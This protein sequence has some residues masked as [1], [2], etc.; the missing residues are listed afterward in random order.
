MSKVRKITI[1]ALG[2]VGTLVAVT[3]VGTILITM[4]KL[5]KI[6]TR[7]RVKFPLYPYDGGGCDYLPANTYLKEENNSPG[8]IR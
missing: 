8:R 7:G 5:Y 3:G 4:N 2:T 1:K 6:G